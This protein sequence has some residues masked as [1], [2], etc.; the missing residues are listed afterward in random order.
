MHH[1][2]RKYSQSSHFNY[3]KQGKDWKVKV[4]TEQSPISLVKDKAVW[5]TA[6]KL[7]FINYN[8]TLSG[9][10]KIINN[11]HTVKMSI[12][13]VDDGHYPSVCGCKLDSIYQAAQLHFHWGSPE[14]KGSEHMINSSRYDAEL[15]IL[16]Q[17]SAYA[18]KEDAISNPDGFVVLAIMLKSVPE[19]PKQTPRILNKLFTELNNVRDYNETSTFEGPLCL[20][21]I[22][23]GME[24]KEF[25]TYKG[26]LTTPPCAEVVN[27]FVFPKPIDVGEK[28]LKNFWLL[29]DDRG[30]PLLNNYRGIQCLHDRT[31]YYRNEIENF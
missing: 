13:P 1:V 5:S 30:C 8:K 24:R 12:P 3:D 21:D 2:V 28:C 31:V 9:P 17:N 11:G 23:N 27:W 20:R 22:L 7:N 19:C 10:L 4:G 25:F 18:S 16:H 26:S 29:K 6:P 14:S 15:H